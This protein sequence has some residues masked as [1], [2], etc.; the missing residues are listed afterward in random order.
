MQVRSYRHE[1]IP[2]MIRIWNEI[3]DEGIA[4]PQEETLTLEIPGKAQT[5]GT[6]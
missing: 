1:D 2:Q 4:F 3:V 5:G 6:D